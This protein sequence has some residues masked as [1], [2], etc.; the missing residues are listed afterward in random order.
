MS[1]PDEAHAE[2]K[3]EKKPDKEK[4]LSATIWG[5]VGIAIG[6]LLGAVVLFSVVGA[7][8]GMSIN[9]FASAVANIAQA[10]MNAAIQLST[11]S[12]SIRVF[13]TGISGVIMT[14][15]MYAILIVGI[16]AISQWIMASIN[17]KSS[18]EHH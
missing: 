2:K 14:I 4:S 5:Y 17:K 15:L 11:V 6:V 3:D 8:G 18:G 9:A 12:A 10:M 16:I 1:K 7:L 13:G